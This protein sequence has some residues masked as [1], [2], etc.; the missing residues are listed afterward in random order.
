MEKTVRL[1][2]EQWQVVLQCLDKNCVG[3]QNASTIL[4][5]FSA[6]ANQLQEVKEE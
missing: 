5:V 3:V 2:T 1:T 4:P 6:I